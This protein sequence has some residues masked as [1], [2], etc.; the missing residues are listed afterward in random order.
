MFTYRFRSRMFPHSY[1]NVSREETV[2]LAR[3]IPQIHDRLFE[4]EKLLERPEARRLRLEVGC[5]TC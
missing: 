2:A 1:P 5:V 4:L 3:L